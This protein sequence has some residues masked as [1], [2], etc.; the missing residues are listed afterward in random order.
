MSESRR[1][2]TTN[3]KQE[4]KAEKNNVYKMDVII[5][6]WKSC[7]FSKL[8]GPTGCG[9]SR[10]DPRTALLRGSLRAVPVFPSPS[11]VVV[12]YV[13]GRLRNDLEMT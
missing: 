3:E 8:H 7:G 12:A 13:R 4:C 9:Q 10:E 2:K 1:E 5:H 6:K 11:R